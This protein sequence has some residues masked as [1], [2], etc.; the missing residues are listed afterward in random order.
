MNLSDIEAAWNSARKSPAKT[1]ALLA[2]AVVFTAMGVV[3]TTYLGETTK[4]FTKTAKLKVVAVTVEEPKSL[5]PVLNIHLLN[6]GGA[7]AFLTGISAEIV[8]RIPFKAAVQ[9]SGEY[10]LLIDEDISTLHVSHEIK[11]DGVDLIR[12]RLAAAPRNLACFITLRLRLAYN[13]DQLV[14]SEPIEIAFLD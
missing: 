1:L 9:P 2:V 13:K 10:D 6:S 8:S 11:S 4:L 5:R 14:F 3:G 7:T 12:V